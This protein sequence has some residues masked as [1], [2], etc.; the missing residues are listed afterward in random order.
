M[1]KNTRGAVA[2]VVLLAAALGYVIYGFT[3]SWGAVPATVGLV[4]G[5]VLVG[6]EWIRRQPGRQP[7]PKVMATARVIGVVV[8]PLLLVAGA[9]GRLAD[10]LAVFAAGLIAPFLAFIVIATPI[11]ARQRPGYWSR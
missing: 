1:S 10:Q 4:A 9:S 5:S 3:T 6:I 7:N 8:Y 2:G 11:V